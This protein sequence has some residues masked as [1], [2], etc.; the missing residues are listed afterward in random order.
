MITPHSAKEAKEFFVRKI[1]DAAEEKGIPL[2]RAEQY[3]LRWAEEDRSFPVDEALTA[4]FEKEVSMSAYEKKI[5]TLVAHAYRRDVE[6]RPAAKDEYR[7]AYEALKQKSDYLFV[8]I[9][10]GVGRHLNRLRAFFGMYESGREYLLKAILQGILAAFLLIAAL[11]TLAGKSWSFGEFK[12]LL[13]QFAI[14]IVLLL[15][16]FSSVRRYKSH[17]RTTSDEPHTS[18]PRK[19]NLSRNAA[20]GNDEG[21]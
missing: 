13:P 17:K 14:G 5:A 19:K 6:R 1:T 20:A 3:M 18:G 2:S 21:A 15:L 10:K 16:A 11:L 7:Q 8:I 4:E 12:E 9:D